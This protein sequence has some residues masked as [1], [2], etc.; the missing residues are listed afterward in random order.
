MPLTAFSWDRYGYL[1][2]K[3]QSGYV[4]HDQAQTV[5]DGKNI[6]VQIADL[7]APNYTASHELLHLWWSFGVSTGVLFTDHRWW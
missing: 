4:R 5:Q 7:R 2:G 1:I 6:I 3:L